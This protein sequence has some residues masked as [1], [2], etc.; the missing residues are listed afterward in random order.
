MC[1]SQRFHELEEIRHQWV[2]TINIKHLVYLHIQY[3]FYIC[4]YINRRRT[5]AYRVELTWYLSANLGRLKCFEWS[6][7]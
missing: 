7:F 1:C 5:G 4:V 3:I 2:F 6:E